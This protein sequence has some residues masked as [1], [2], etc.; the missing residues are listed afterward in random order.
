[1]PPDLWFDELP[2]R[3]VLGAA[4]NRVHGVEAGRELT[5]QLGC[6]NGLIQIDEIDDKIVFL[7]T[8]VS[9]F[10]K[11]RARL[12]SVFELMVLGDLIARSHSCTILLTRAILIFSD[13]LV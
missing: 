12:E 8:A 1:M 10:R 9:N 11:I 13:A 2:V 3:L 5:A 7:F 4:A 6:K